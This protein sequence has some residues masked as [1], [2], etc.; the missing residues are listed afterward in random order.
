MFFIPLVWVVWANCFNYFLSKAQCLAF[1]LK[2]NLQKSSGWNI[3]LNRNRVTKNT[4]ENKNLDKNKTQK[5]SC[6][7]SKDY[8]KKGKRVWLCSPDGTQ[9]FRSEQTSLKP[10]LSCLQQLG[11]QSDS[12]LSL[13]SLF[14][15][16]PPP[17]GECSL[18]SA[19]WLEANPIMEVLAASASLQQYWL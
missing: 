18:W 19:K 6:R 5:Q 9:V 3:N 17:G 7:E 2:H 11:Q 16:R 13:L 14:H 8:G 1:S 10:V 12:W 15:G 4:E